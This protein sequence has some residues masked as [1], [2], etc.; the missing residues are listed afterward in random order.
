MSNLKTKQ[1]KQRQQQKNHRFQ[2]GSALGKSTT[3]T[4]GERRGVKL[5]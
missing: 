2:I 1:N 3:E 5:E 4:R